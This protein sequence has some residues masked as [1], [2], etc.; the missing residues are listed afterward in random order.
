VDYKVDTLLLVRPVPRSMN[1]EISS[2]F[3]TYSLRQLGTNGNVLVHTVT[4]LHIEKMYIHLMI[5]SILLLSQSKNIFQNK[6]S[7]VSFE[8]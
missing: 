5:A 8:K 3:S 4:V 6:R 2:L 7:V 1:Y